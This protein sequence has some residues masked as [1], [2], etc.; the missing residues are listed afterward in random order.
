[1]NRAMAGALGLVLLAA[2]AGLAPYD[3]GRLYVRFLERLSFQAEKL[4]GERL[5]AFHRGSL[6]IFDACDAG[7]MRD[8][9]AKFTELEIRLASQ[10][11]AN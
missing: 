8:A 6:R 1:M 10:S 4:S 11:R 9:P 7:H 5:A 2:M 3:C